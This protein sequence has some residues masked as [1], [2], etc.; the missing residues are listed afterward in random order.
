MRLAGVEIV[1]V[2][3]R[4]PANVA[5]A[6]RAMK[7][8][9][10][11][12]LRI[13]EPPVGLAAPDARA[14]AYGAW[15]LLDGAVPA[16]S[17]AEAVASSGLVVGTSAR[18]VPG[19][20]TPRRLAMEIQDRSP[21]SIVFGPEASGLTNQELAL[22]HARVTIP[23]HPAQPSLNLA[24]AVLIVAYELWVAGDP[25][26]PSLERERA[27]TGDV[28]AALAALRQALLAI[29]YLNP[30][31]PEALLAEFRALL[32]RAGPT[33][34]EVALLRGMAR[35]ILWASGSAPRIAPS[36]GSSG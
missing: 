29:G 33:A 3:P 32:A 35:Q 26:A 4:R 15:E 21:V 6:C 24:Q 14:L 12:T 5:A 1:L 7:N 17:L 25:P 18:E 19:H 27:A 22:C 2:R 23:A 31:N 34:R 28:E 10:L 9:G 13:V 8:M 36:G 11:R 16:A 20:W 30:D